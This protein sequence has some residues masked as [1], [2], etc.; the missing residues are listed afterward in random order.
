M[1][2]HEGTNYRIIQGQKAKS[3]VVVSENFCYLIEKN[4][5]N[6]PKGSVVYLKCQ[7]SSCPGRATIKNGLLTVSTNLKKQHDCNQNAPHKVHKI[8]VNEIIAR[9]KARAATEGSSYYVRQLYV[10]SNA[11]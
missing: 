3:R 4:D 7:V 10:I 11:C 2:D 5:K 1:G 9:M 6:N 8:A